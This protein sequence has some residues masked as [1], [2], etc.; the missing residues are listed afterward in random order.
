[1]KKKTQNILFIYR[2]LL[3]DGIHAVGI[4][5]V[6]VRTWIRAMHVILNTYR[7]TVCVRVIA[8]VCVQ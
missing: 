6:H 7:K 4:S 2:N 5:Y 3:I 1:M 8:R